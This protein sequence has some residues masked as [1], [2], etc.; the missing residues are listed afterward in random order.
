MSSIVQEMTIEE[1]IDLFMNI[2]QG[3]ETFDPSKPVLV[4]KGKFRFGRKIEEKSYP[5][6]FVEWQPVTVVRSSGT[7]LVKKDQNGSFPWFV[8]E[9]LENCVASIFRF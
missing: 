2:S 7:L 8:L 5:I 4:V 1:G 9:P 6:E 3:F